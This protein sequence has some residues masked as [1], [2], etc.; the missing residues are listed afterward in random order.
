MP[1]TTDKNDEDRVYYDVLSALVAQKKEPK[2]K[3]EDVPEITKK[4][5]GQVA[6]ISPILH[7]QV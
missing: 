7:S 6:S 3:Q 1:L 5:Q 2:S 4:I